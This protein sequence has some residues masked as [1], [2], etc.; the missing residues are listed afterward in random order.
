MNKVVTRFSPSPTGKLH[1]GGI[2]TCLYS[3]FY[4]KKHNGKFIIRIEDTDSKR[5]DPDAEKY[6]KDALDWVGILPD[7]DPWNGGKNGPYRQSERDYSIEIELLLS[8][9]SAYYA[10]DTN[11]DLE[12]ARKNDSNFSYNAKSRMNMKNSLSLPKD[13]VDELLKM[14]YVIRFKVPENEEITFNDEIRGTIT[15]NTKE[16]D[17]KVMV[18]SDGIPTYHLAN[19]SDDYNMGVTHVIRGEEWL[20][21]TPLHILIYKSLDRNPPIF[22]HLPLLLNP[23]GRG[24]LSKRSALKYGF[25]IVPFGGNSLNEKGEIVFYKGFKDEGYDPKPFINFLAL[26][27]W[28]PGKDIEVMNL[29]DMINSFSLDRVHKAG[30][31][32]DI[33]KAKWINS[34]Y[35]KTT[36][37]KDLIDFINI[38]DDRYSDDKL[39]KIITLAKDRATFKT[40]LNH[41]VDLFF[42]TPTITDYSKID[43][44][45]TK[46][47]SSFVDNIDSVDFNDN[48]SIKLTISSVCDGFGIKIGKVMP[49]LRTALVGG[50]SGPDL[51]TTMSILGKD[52]VKFRIINSIKTV[53]V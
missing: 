47:M 4:A 2:R 38:K 8:N 39:D 29:D 24:K 26:L 28:N 35:L 5:F 13:K 11:D 15:F 7:E 23:D 27:G 53:T 45:Y 3:Y 6:I 49:G 16:M 40:D 19:T 51:M 14:P 18:K 30:A 25:P 34:H 48:D 1:I 46:V 20:S 33:D 36:D 41:I 37:N 10:F 32:F 9:G 21:S 50:I 52:Q 42:D 12:L 43:D 17:D 31:R 22:S 44:N